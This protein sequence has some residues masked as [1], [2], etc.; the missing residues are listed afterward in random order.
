MKSAKFAKNQDEVC[1]IFEVEE[2]KRLL[3]IKMFHYEKVTTTQFI[4]FYPHFIHHCLRRGN[5]RTQ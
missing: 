5:A 3:I 2:V 1:V 4:T